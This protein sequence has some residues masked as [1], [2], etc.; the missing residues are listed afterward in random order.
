M[1]RSWIS[2]PFAFL[3]SIPTAE[4]SFSERIQKKSMDIQTPLEFN[5]KKCLVVLNRS[6][7]ENLRRIWDEQR[8]ID[9]RLARN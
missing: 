5:F 1:L 8:T 3:Q 6:G 7:Q 9:P 2:K 4:K